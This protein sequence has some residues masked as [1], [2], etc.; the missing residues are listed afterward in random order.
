MPG[1]LEKSTEELKGIASEFEN[2]R[3]QLINNRV[4]SEDRKQRLSNQIV[5]PLQLI[6]NQSMRQLNEHVERLEEVLDRLQTSLADPSVSELADIEAEGAIEQAN[7]VLQQIDQVLGVLIN[8][9]TQNEL[10]EIVREMIRQ[11]KEI[12]ERTKKERKKKAFEGLL[13]E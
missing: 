11:Q 1:Q 13:D 4:D 10:L 3:L 5:T 7:L 8:Y 12:A 9:E 6:A 2:I